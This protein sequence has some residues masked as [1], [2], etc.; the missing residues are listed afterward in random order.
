V[1]SHLG[2][3]LE[4][5]LNSQRSLLLFATLSSEFFY[6]ILS[7]SRMRLHRVVRCLG[8]KIYK[9][10]ASEFFVLLAFKSWTLVYVLPYKDS[11]FS[12][13]FT[14]STFTL[15]V[16]NNWASFQTLFYQFFKPG[17]LRRFPQVLHLNRRKLL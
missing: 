15:F 4:S 5:S 10:A 11:Q 13:S 6:C 1:K 7:A 9:I 3:L 17:E 16:P 8:E 14:H 12:F 2:A